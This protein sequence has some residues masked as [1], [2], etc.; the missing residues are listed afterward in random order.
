MASPTP[1]VRSS[2]SIFPHDLSPDKKIIQMNG[3]GMRLL[4]QSYDKVFKKIA[5]SYLKDG[6]YSIGAIHFWT[7]VKG[8]LPHLSYIFENTESLGTEFNNVACY[9]TGLLI[10]LEIHIVK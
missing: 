5:A 6:N 2:G 10:F 8:D 3:V 9:V 7:I 1:R 4:V